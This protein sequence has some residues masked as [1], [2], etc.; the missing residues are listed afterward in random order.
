MASIMCEADSILTKTR[1]LLAPAK[2]VL[3]IFDRLDP[4]A[5]LAAKK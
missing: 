5:E 2:P 4:L 3:H 1:A